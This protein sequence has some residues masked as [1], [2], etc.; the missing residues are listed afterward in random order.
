V[1]TP[2]FYSP[3]R[4]WSMTRQ[5]L[6]AKVLV[7]SGC[8][9]LFAIQTMGVCGNGTATPT[10]T[11]CPCTQTQF[12]TVL[13]VGVLVMNCDPLGGPV[14]N[15]GGS[16]YKIPATPCGGIT[17]IQPNEPAK[18]TQ[19]VAAH[20]NTKSESACGSEATSE[21]TL[22]AAAASQKAQATFNSWL[23]K[24]LTRGK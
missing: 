21:A 24:N 4:R 23:E 17:Q 20:L 18:S 15:C 13:C 19:L 9:L 8:Y 14:K 5:S 12:Q 22:A 16:C 11:M 6:A 2:P 1:I 3:N 10:E 7:L